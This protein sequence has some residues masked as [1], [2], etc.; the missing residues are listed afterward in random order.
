MYKVQTFLKSKRLSQQ[1]GVSFVR[2][3]ELSVD[4]IRRKEKEVLVDIDFA[5]NIKDNGK[6]YRRFGDIVRVLGNEESDEDSD[7]AI[8]SEYNSVSGEEDESDAESV[9]S[10]ASIISVYSQS[11][12]ISVSSGSVAIE[13][14]RINEDEGEAEWSPSD[15]DEP[16]L[17]KTDD[18]C[19][20]IDSRGN[21]EGFIDYDYD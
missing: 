15:D 8:D 6:N 10:V 9:Y 3:D 7:N 5:A 11:S 2:L 4:E 13:T 12:V 14:L 16:K 18:D 20:K 21:I 17:V 1:Y 19:Y